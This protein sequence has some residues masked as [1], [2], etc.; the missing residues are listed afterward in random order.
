VI[1]LD[2]YSKPVSLELD[3]NPIQHYK[4]ESVKP[5]EFDPEVFVAKYE[6]LDDE[7]KS[8]YPFEIRVP[9]NA[10]PESDS[11][12]PVFDSVSNLYSRK[13][14]KLTYGYKI[15]QLII[16]E[17]YKQT[18]QAPPKKAATDKTVTGEVAE[19]PN[20]KKEKSAPDAL[21]GETGTNA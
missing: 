15:M 2:V 7:K 14:D 21:P 12:K 8:F 11:W 16:D 20:A 4:V 18:K 17:I 1:V 10:L 6:V 5:D 3:R 13:E 9:K 19:K